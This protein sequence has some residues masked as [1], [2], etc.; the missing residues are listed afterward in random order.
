MRRDTQI[1]THIILQHTQ[2]RTRLL[3]H[4]YV[5]LIRVEMNVLFICQML[6]INVYIHTD[7]AI[8]IVC[9]W[10]FELGIGFLRE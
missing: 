7:D 5:F 1:N 3:M 9:S 8:A 4:V 10:N 6:E 2:C